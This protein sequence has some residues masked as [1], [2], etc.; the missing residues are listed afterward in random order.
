MELS[1]SFT[2]FNKKRNDKNNYLSLFKRFIEKKNKTTLIKKNF[3]KI[4]YF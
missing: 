2:L 1:R 3:A 4:Y